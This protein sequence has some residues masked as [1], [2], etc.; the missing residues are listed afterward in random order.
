M[1]QQIL[2]STIT[3]EEV[4]D[5][6]KKL[7]IKA[8]NGNRSF[9][10]SVWKTK[11]DGTDSQ[12]YA[13]FKSM[14]L[15]VGSTVMI[16]Y[17]IDEY[18][19]EI[20]GFP[21]KVQSK[22]IINFREASAQGSQTAPQ[23]KSS[24]GEANRG[25]SG[26]SS[27]YKDDTFWDMK[28]YKQCLWGYWLERSKGKPAYAVLSPEEMDLVWGVFKSIEADGAK[29]FSQ[30]DLQPSLPVIQQDEDYRQG[31]ADNMDVDSVPFWFA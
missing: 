1:D 4:V 11:Q 22:K 20:G 28:A 29:R 10:Y 5:K 9:T 19:T 13:Q 17:V 2:N 21:K 30:P 7:S 8:N 6:E 18:E 3:I 31:S 23:D 16:G 25:Q 12:T 26:H 27:G 24:N 14:G 15:K